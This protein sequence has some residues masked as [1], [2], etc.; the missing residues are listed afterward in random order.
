MDVF[1]EWMA[2]QR[3]MGL[4]TYYQDSAPERNFLQRRFRGKE[5]I[6]VLD[7]G[8]N[9]GPFAE[10]VL[11]VVPTAQI[12]C[13]E[14]NPDSVAELEKSFG[15]RVQVVPLG[16]SDRAEE[17]ILYVP[18]PGEGHSQHCSFYGETLPRNSHPIVVKTLTLDGYCREQGIDH[19]D[20]LKVDVEGHELAVF[21]G[22]R[23]MLRSGRVKCLMFEFNVHNVYSRT[24][25]KDFWDE[26][27]RYHLG[28]LLENTTMIFGKYDPGVC[29][30]F[31]Y[32]TVIGL[33]KDE[34][35]S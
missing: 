1:N 25:F 24:F 28:R 14:P 10:I 35:V 6:L 27:S 22:A 31:T 3:K 19:V 4:G 11:D 32:Q 15:S 2:A 30:Q 9:T 13:F 12:H 5:D 21:R 8:A 16:V 33:L 18:L 29:E 17:K 34:N 7:V 23:D 20:L 26:L